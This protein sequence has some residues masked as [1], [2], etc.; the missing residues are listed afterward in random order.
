MHFIKHYVLVVL[1]VICNFAFSQDITLYQQFNGNYD[2]T[3]FGNTL[4]ITENGANSPCT[5]LTS[6]S[7]ALNLEPN[8]EVVAAFLYWAGS[9]PGDFDVTFNQVPISAERTFNLTYN[10]SG[11][12][13]IYFAAFAEVTQQVQNTGNGNYTLADLDLTDVIPAYCSP[14]G[15]GTNFGGWAVTVVYED[16]TLPINQVNIFDGLESVNRNNQTLEITLN[17]LMVL[18][19]EGAKIGFLAWEGDA[20]IAVNETLRING[21]ILSNPPLNPPNNA[22]NGTNSFT[23]SNT[24]YNMDIDFYPIS[25]Y[26]NVGDTSATIQLTSGQ[27]FVMINNI[28]TVLNTELPDATISIDNTVGGTECNNRELT[29]DYT[30]YNLNSTAL[31]PAPTPIAFYADNILVAQAATINDIPIDGQ[32]SGS[33]SFTVPAE[34]GADF[35][36]KAVVDD[37]GNGTGIVRELNEDNNEDEIAF[38][39]L[40]NP[41]INRL[42]DLEKC[43]IVGDEYFDLTEATS[44]IDPIYELSF[45]LSE[46]DAEN[47]TNPILNPETFRN[48]ENPQTI[49][50]RVSNPDCFLIDSFTVTVLDCPLPDATISLD[51]LLGDMECGNRE[52]TIDYTVYNLESLGI[53]PA[54][55]PIAFYADDLLIAQSA[56]VT[57]IPIDGYEEGSITFTVPEEIGSDFILKIVVD[58]I[59]NGTGIIEELDETNNEDGIPVHLLINPIITGLKNLENCEVIDGD[60]FDLTESTSEIDPIY[61]LSFHLSEEDAENNVNSIPHPENF[62]NT[63]N[64]QTIYVRVANPDC[65]LVDSFTVTVI[66]CPIPD[67]TVD[68]PEIN[69]CRNRILLLPFTVYNLEATGPLPANVPIAF[70]ADEIPLNLA[71]TKNSIPVGGSETNEVQ[72]FLPDNLADTFTLTAIVNEDFNGNHTVE[73]IRM[74]NN[75]FSRQVSFESI[76][77]IPNLPNLIKC[78]EGFNTAT[79]D[80]TVQDN[81]VYSGSDGLV[82]Y[83]TSLEDALEN[84]N[85]ISSP[86]DYKNVSDPQT[87]YVRFDNDICFAT[88]SFLLKTEKCA[89]FIPQGFSPNNDGIND[90]FEISNLLDVYPNFELEIYSRNGNLIHTG[91]NQDG[92]WDGVA[93]KG[94]LFRGSLVPVGT[95]YYVLMLND[96]NYPEPFIGWVYVNY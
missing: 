69:A 55:T 11:T 14:P 56:T 26:I 33:V 31:L 71:Y 16:S 39:L 20:E 35:I 5:I 9:G 81:L 64:P 88:A 65:F 53:L 90:V 44:Q 83:F 29:V 48:T 7:A 15:S 38:H 84:S 32:E 67:A 58:D 82:V 42:H 51:N 6:S 87:I 22:F 19:T 47:N 13:Y 23:G 2:Y 41:V 1:L 17:N 86:S 74:D 95:Y 85:P 10:Q 76:P 27:D 94:L 62:Q 57:D 50:I 4:N 89:P 92:F 18:D 80:L 91:H 75:S 12:D 72:L 78:D 96:P 37:I 49:Y 30:V 34:I 45:H 70:Y 66:F 43:D 21:Y 8:Q 54:G 3:A 40:E 46:E 25:G 52:L 93:T 68:F 24:L 73:E 79:F 61:D 60:H 63:E 36:L 77:P 28:I 59:G